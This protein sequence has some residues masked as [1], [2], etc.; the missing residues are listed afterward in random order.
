MPVW[1][2]PGGS[3]VRPAPEP[4]PGRLPRR[5][6]QPGL[7]Q[8]CSPRSKRTTTRSPHGCGPNRSEAVSRGTAPRRTDGSTSDTAA[9]IDGRR[10]AD[11]Q[12]APRRITTLAAAGAPTA[13]DV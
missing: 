5:G 8:C 12:E 2:T 9:G 6:E 4:R 7:A 3:A 13:E 10:L 1:E 11:E